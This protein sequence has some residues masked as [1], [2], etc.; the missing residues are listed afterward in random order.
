MATTSLK[1]TQIIEKD[2]K[3]A[4]DGSEWLVVQHPS[5]KVW[6]VAASLLQVGGTGNAL[7]TAEKPKLVGSEAGELTGNIDGI[8]TTFVVPEGEFIAGTARVYRNGIRQRGVDITTTPATGTVV[9][10]YAPDVGDNIIIDYA[11]A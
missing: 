8:N 3:A 5:G 1:K 7:K 9:M 4:I 6:K 2:T 11:I 10:S